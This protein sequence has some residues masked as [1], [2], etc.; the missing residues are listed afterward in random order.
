[1]CQKDT[2]LKIDLAKNPLLSANLPLL[3]SDKQGVPP[4][5]TFRQPP[6]ITSSVSIAPLQSPRVSG[7]ERHARKRR[8]TC[9]DIG[10]GA[11]NMATVFLW[12][13]QETNPKDY[14]S[15]TDPR[16]LRLP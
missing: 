5:H 2:I 14:P 1:M 8:M 6:L 3:G 10:L 9:Q 11:P 16:G 15:K 13:P 12:F 4:H 7:M